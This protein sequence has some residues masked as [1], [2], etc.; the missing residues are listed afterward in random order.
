MNGFLL[1]DG[2]RRRSCKFD[3]RLSKC[4]FARQGGATTVGD[5]A[6]GFSID[7]VKSRGLRRQVGARKKISEA[8]FRFS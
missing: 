1:L 3:V 8:T 7:F 5:L 6:R 2:K 4:Q